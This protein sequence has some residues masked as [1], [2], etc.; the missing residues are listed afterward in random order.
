VRVLY[1][2]FNATLKGRLKGDGRWMIDLAD[3]GQGIRK[4]L[5]SPAELRLNPMTNTDLRLL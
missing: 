1:V 3:E 5:L 4:P 2:S